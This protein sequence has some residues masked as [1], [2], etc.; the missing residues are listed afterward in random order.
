MNADITHYV[1][2]YTPTQKPKTA[3]LVVL[4]RAD[5]GN[6]AIASAFKLKADFN[7][8]ID[9]HIRGLGGVL[10]SDVDKAIYS[11]SAPTVEDFFASMSAP[12]N[13]RTLTDEMYNGW[14]EQAG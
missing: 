4:P 8:L 1:S 2:G 6:A 5:V 12:D 13:E 10:A 11:V 14:F 3:S 7:A 9:K